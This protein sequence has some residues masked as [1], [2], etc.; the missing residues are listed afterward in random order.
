MTVDIR[1]FTATLVNKAT[2]II[3]Q[4]PIVDTIWQAK[5][6]ARLDKHA[7]L[8]AAP[9]TTD[10]TSGPLTRKRKPPEY[11]PDWMFRLN[12]DPNQLLTAT[13][14]GTDCGDLADT[15]AWAGHGW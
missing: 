1:V 11:L 7:P 12:G 9:R 15:E 8:P 14:E 6:A 2:R 10:S 13:A 5:T 3:V 4:L